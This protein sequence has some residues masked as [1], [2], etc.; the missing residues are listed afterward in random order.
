MNCGTAIAEGGK[1][2]TLQDFCTS[3]SLLLAHTVLPYCSVYS[4]KL[5]LLASRRGVWTQPPSTASV[6]NLDSSKLLAISGLP[7][8]ESSVAKT[9]LVHLWQWFMEFFC[10]GLTEIIP[11]QTFAELISPPGLRGVFSANF[12]C[13]FPSTQDEA[14]NTRETELT[15]KCWSLKTARWQGMQA[16]K[17]K[18]FI[19]RGWCL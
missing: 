2:T 14:P 19:C 10:V 8:P 3:K 16:D 12:L 17:A 6:R 18:H 11:V 4:N 7:T 13:I 9:S 15:D 1:Q 5:L